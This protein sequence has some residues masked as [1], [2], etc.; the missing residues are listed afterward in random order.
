MTHFEID[1][2]IAVSDPDGVWT[3]MQDSQMYDAAEY[4]EIK[5]FD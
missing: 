2:L 5:Y 1:E 3:M 4:I